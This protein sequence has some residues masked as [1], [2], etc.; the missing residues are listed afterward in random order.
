MI[1]WAPF[2][3]F[4]QPPTQF[5]AI[6]QKICNE[7]YRPLLKIFT[8]QPKAKITVNICGVLT[9][10]LND[11]GARD[12]IDG[13]KQ[14]ALSEKL[15]FVESA[16]Y[17]A[18]LPLMP[19][20]EIH[21]QINLNH[22]TNEF[23]FKE[24]YEVRGFFP[25][26]MCYSNQLA[27]SLST[28]EY[29]WMLLGGVACP[30]AWPLELI[31]KAPLGKKGINIFY[32]D[33]ILS[34]KISFQDIDSKGFIADLTALAKDK[35][36]IYV[37]T[38]MDAETFGHHIHNWEKVFLE[39]VY[40]TLESQQPAYTNIK[41]K[42]DLAQ[43]H[44]NIID[45]GTNGQIEVVTISELLEHFPVK[46]S[47]NPFASSWSTTKEDIEKKNYYP[48]WK[49]EANPIH[50]LQWEHLNLCLEL[51]N[52][53]K[54]VAKDKESIHFAEIARALLD[55]AVYSCQFWWANKGR[56]WDINLVN[57]GLILQE[58][59]LFN[60]YKAVISSSCREDFKKRTYRSLIATRDIANKIRDLLLKG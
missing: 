21:R 38:A 4:Y 20:D 8:E 35:K 60:A 1:Y 48:L 19:P 46:S 16:K 40:S 29:E 53:S 54:S 17:H 41:Q 10:M 18:I 12:I 2:L 24:A 27:S 34:N 51:V 57:K 59:V 50:N 49:N 42:T 15:E 5:H 39:D 9:E 13:L 55:R 23:F 44:K 32:R 56:T 31:Y 47:K 36:D 28:M 26:E 25:P 11:H 14:L 37:I 52:A 58:E 6:L 30:Q 45:T 43:Q 3:H 33:D 22:K 7:S